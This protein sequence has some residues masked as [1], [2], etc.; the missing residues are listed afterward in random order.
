VPAAV[1]VT[2]VVAA[3]AAS[4]ALAGCGQIDSALSKQVA[5]VRFKPGTTVQTL[6]RARSACSHVPNL[7]VLPAALHADDPTAGVEV[8]Y[9]ANHATGRDLDLLQQCLEK[10]PQVAGVAMMDTAGRSL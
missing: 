2:A 9:Q 3:V 1:G 7:I 6:L 5:I 8:R 10:F 4:L